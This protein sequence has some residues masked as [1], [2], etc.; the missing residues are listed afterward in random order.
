[1]KHYRATCNFVWDRQDIA[2]GQ[3]IKHDDVPSKLRSHIPIH[4]KR[5]RLEEIPYV[6]AQK[7]LETPPPKP[8]ESFHPDLQEAL[9]KAEIIPPPRRRPGRPKAK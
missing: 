3:I 8:S 6:E 1:M 4:V 2:R 7:A 5:K 9:A